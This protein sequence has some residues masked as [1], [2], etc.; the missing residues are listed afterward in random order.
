V[1]CSGFRGSPIT[2]DAGLLAFRAGRH[3][4]LLRQSVFG[5]VAG[6]EDGNGID[7]LCYEP[8][9]RWEVAD[10]AITGSA[11]SA[12]R[13]PKNRGAVADQSTREPDQERCQGRQ[14]RPLRSLPDGRGRG[15]VVDVPTCR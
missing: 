10:R 2:S 7:P 13:M 4:L 14:P 12:S 15:T 5:R 6:Y 8:V 3:P 1:Q 11:G 9:M